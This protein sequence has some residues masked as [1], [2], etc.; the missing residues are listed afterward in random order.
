MGEIGQRAGSVAKLE[1]AQEDGRRRTLREVRSSG[2]W[3]LYST[4]EERR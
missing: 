2:G 4:T 3:V 1:R